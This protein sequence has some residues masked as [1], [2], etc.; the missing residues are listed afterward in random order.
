MK[1]I[2]QVALSLIIAVVILIGLYGATQTHDVFFIIV[3]SLGMVGWM[4]IV[5]RSLMH[6]DNYEHKNIL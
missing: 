1:R 4:A 6:F 5:L 2:L 3:G